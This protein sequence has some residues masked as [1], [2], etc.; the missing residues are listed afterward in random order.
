M[1]F[2]LFAHILTSGVALAAG[3]AALST[4]KG[5]LVHRRSGIVFVYM[6]VM[7]GATGIMLAALRDKAPALNIPVALFTSYLALTSF[8]T[9]RRPVGWTRGVDVGLLVL[10][11]CVA[12]TDTFF[13][14]TAIT[15]GGKT[16]DGTPAVALLIFAT[17]AVTAAVGDAK[18]LRSGART[19]RARLARH[20]WRM[21][22]ALMV[23]ATSFLGRIPRLLPTGW[24][25]PAPLL[26]VPVLAVLA[27]LLWWL[28]RVRPPRRRPGAQPAGA[29]RAAGRVAP[30]DAGSPL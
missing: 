18:V 25:I 12:L 19:G 26:F 14:I 16:S 29:L 7:M 23:A 4:T 11:I 8:A 1:D 22:F 10:V 28:W 15:L 24:K 2:L 21:C 17:L 6:M 27:M 5:A 30:Q 3:Y 9:M 20:L 13:A